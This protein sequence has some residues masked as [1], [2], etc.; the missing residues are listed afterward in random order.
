MLVTTTKYWRT[1]KLEKPDDWERFVSTLIDSATLM[2]MPNALL[3][4]TASIMGGDRKY[5]KSENGKEMPK[6]ESTKE[7]KGDAYL[8]AVVESPVLPNLLPRVGGM[9][10]VADPDAVLKISAAEWEKYYANLPRE[11][12]EKR[13]NLYCH[14]GLVLGDNYLQFKSGLRDPA[15]LICKLRKQIE[16]PT[17][18]RLLKLKRKLDR[19]TLADYGGNVESYAASIERTAAKLNS[20]GKRVDDQD[21]WLALL[22]GMPDDGIYEVI[23]TMMIN[24]KKT[25]FREAVVKLSAHEA[26]KKDSDEQ[27][28][29]LKSYAPRSGRGKNGRRGDRDNRRRNDD[30][31]KG[32]DPKPATT[33]AYG[34]REFVR[35]TITSWFSTVVALGRCVTMSRCSPIFR[36]NPKAGEY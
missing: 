6:L 34:H 26:R 23:I 35:W 22:S 1:T 28:A 13:R 2:Q 18:V 33:R 32:N 5:A 21:K 3:A 14:I 24:E 10:K 16:G 17:L 4:P 12:L 25:T 15:L 7:L 30:G 11:E 9:S 31:K 29:A 27:L 19:E 8:K 20:L 36:L